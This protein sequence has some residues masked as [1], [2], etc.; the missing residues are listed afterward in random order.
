M[1]TTQFVIA[2]VFTEKRFCGNQLAVFPH[3]E[4]LGTAVMQD[5][6]REMNYSETTFILPP[7]SEGDFRL[8]IFTPAKELPFAGHP[9]VGSAYVIVSER[10]KTWGGAVT[11]VALETKVGVINVEVATATGQAGRT[12]MT[13]PLPR[14]MSRFTGIDALAR[15]LSIDSSGISGTDLPIEVIYNG[16]TVMIV[17]VKS[18]DVIRNLRPKTS[19]LE[20]VAASVNAETV[21]VF[22]TETV[23]PSSNCHSRVFAPGAGVGEDPATGSANGPLGYYLARRRLVK[24]NGGSFSIVSEQGFEMKRP[25]ILYIEVGFE[26][27]GEQASK[28][29]VGGD[30]VIAGKGELFLG[31]SEY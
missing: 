23:L 2:D 5:I 16:I 12:T 27:D 14:V 3:A 22:T 6:A 21:L 24:A 28:V 10:M 13:Q 20:D 19:E 31:E 1:K 7:E 30:V 18:L 25:S 8:R 29:L 11:P 15:A 26:S 4:G 17:P 9:I